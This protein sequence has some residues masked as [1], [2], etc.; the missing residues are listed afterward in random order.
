VSNQRKIKPGLRGDYD[1]TCVVCLTPTDT[2]LAFRGPAEFLIA[3]LTVLGVP[4]DQAHAVYR[5][6]QAEEGN[7]LAPGQVKDGIHNLLIRVCARCVAR[8]PA[9]FPAPVLAI[10]GAELPTIAPLDGDA[11]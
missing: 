6:S 1:G 11:T 9:N 7:H 5:H 2:G 4:E 10:H 3:G 8:C